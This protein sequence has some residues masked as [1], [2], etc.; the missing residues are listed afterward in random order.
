MSHSSFLPIKQV[1]MLWRQLFGEARTRVLTIYILTML[2]VIVVAIPIFHRLLFNY[3]DTR[4]RE[5]LT[6]ELED[7]QSAYKLW[8]ATAETSERD[9]K[10]FIG[11]FID[12]SRPEDDNIHIFLVDGEFYR[13]NPPGLPKEM[14]LNS[15]LRKQWLNLS[16]YGDLNTLSP[17]IDRGEQSSSDPKVG[18]I[19]YKVVAL[20]K[21]NQRQGL[22][23]L[24][25]LTAGERAEALIGV[26]LFASIALGVIIISFC[27]AWV[28]SY[29]LFTPVR[30]LANTARTISESNLSERLD[31]EGKG[32]LAIL[33]SSFNSMMDRLQSA[34]ESQR[35]FINDASHE[36]RTPITII[37]GHLELMGEDPEDQQETLNLVMDELDRMG[38]FVNDLLLLT[39]SERPDFLR[40]ETIEIAA[41]SEEVLHKAR[42]LAHRNWQVDN[43]GIGKMVGDRQRI[44]GALLNLVNN[45]VQHTQ[46]SDTIEI[47]SEVDRDNV[48]LWVRDTGEGIFPHDQKRIFDR[49]ARAGHHYRRSEGLGLGLPIVQAIVNAHAGRIELSSQRG[50]GSKFTLI[51]PLD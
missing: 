12:M 36:L 13:A 15:D 43:R 25:H 37:Q 32:E 8:A 16:D 18:N 19:I 6:E 27:L 31:I 21:D 23:I 47:G 26:Y 20:N 39:K 9:L 30:A 17:L 35:S 2:G 14:H 24:V 41:L 10:N 29:Q 42:A 4:V 44:T 11:D 45:A 38:R 22:F 5:D 1:F 28:S 51:F 40:L 48:L 34:F 3:I 33:A 50:M 49:F 46:E 7:F